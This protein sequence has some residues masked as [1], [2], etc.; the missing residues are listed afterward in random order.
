MGLYN[1]GQTVSSSSPKLKYGPVLSF[2]PYAHVIYDPQQ[3]QYSWKMKEQRPISSS[4]SAGDCVGSPPGSGGQQPQLLLSRAGEGHGAEQHP[5]TGTGSTAHPQDFTAHRST[6]RDAEGLLTRA[7]S[8][9]TRGNTPHLREG[10]IR[11]DIGKKLFTQQVLKHW[12]RFPR[13]VV[14]ALF[15]QVFKATLDGAWSNPV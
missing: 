2:R 12:Y 1:T 8:D 4:H 9:K 11:L 15:L 3:F 14:P 10:R 6:K 5:S 13:E 7:W